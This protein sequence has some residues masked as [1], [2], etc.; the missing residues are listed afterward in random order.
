MATSL[1]DFSEEL[2]GI[3]TNLAKGV[4]RGQD[5]DCTVEE[6]H[7]LLILLYLAASCSAVCLAITACLSRLRI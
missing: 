4:K 3:A 1:I 2:L 7:Y 6:A 5:V